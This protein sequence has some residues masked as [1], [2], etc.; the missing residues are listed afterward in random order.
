MHGAVSNL[1]QMCRVGKVIKMTIIMKI[2][3]TVAVAV[4]LLIL[5]TS[6]YKDP[7][8]R[9]HKPDTDK[10]DTEDV[11]PTPMPK[12][13]YSPSLKGY[14]YLPVTVKYSTSNSRPVVWKE[15][16]ARILPYLLNFTPDTTIERYRSVT[17]KW[18]SRTDWPKHDAT[19]RFR[20][21]KVGDRWWIIDP[22]GYMH[23]NRCVTSFRKG[24]SARNDVGWKSRFVSDA[25]WVAK[26][27]AELA[28][29]GFHGTGAFCTDAYQL[30]QKH[31][32]AHPEAPLTLAP[33]FGFLS[34]FRTTVGGYPGGNSANAA[35]LVFYD[36]WDAFCKNYVKNGDVKPYLKDPNVL[37]IFSDNEIDFTS[38]SSNNETA[39][40]L[41]RLLNISDASNPARVAAEKWC[42]E[43]LGKDPSVHSKIYYADN[44]RFAGYVAEKYY[45]AVKAALNEADP[46]MMYLGTRLHGTPKYI[47]EVVE[48]AGKYC[49]IV[50]IN[51]YSR[52]SPELTT[53]VKDWAT[54]ANKP[55]IVS[56]F[57]TKGIEDSDLDNTSGAGFGVPTQKERAYAYQH[58]TLG[59]LEA[60]NC[61]GWHWFK[62]QDDDGKDND[63]KPVNKGVYDNSY[64]M[65][66]YLGKYM[67]AVNLNVYDLI[68]FF[69]D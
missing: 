51:Y 39:Y 6:C 54:W 45:S 27:Q 69:G 58:F 9:P 23:F 67:K 8:V 16:K 36:G 63:G 59:L 12:E 35:G 49:D 5:C 66:P 20:V 41:F 31:N 1:I 30:I 68:K 38:A 48:A 2:T 42:R 62:Y 26:T 37:G 14:P 40:L 4:S 33:S 34:Q 19:G 65:Y 21:E 43:V 7:V 61:V 56:E 52:W 60:P 13:A 25:D 11:L 64:K 29:I 24:S 50:S 32:S 17:N 44:C 55:F 22:E 57:Y 3:R 15:E 53:S 46:G 47:Q 28:G 10:S 18:G